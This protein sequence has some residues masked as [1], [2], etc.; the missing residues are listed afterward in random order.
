MFTKS[1]FKNSLLDELKPTEI[2]SLHQTVPQLKQLC[3]LAH[4]KMW[5]LSGHDQKHS[6]FNCRC[7][8]PNSIR[9]TSYS[10]NY[11]RMKSCNVIHKCAVNI[12]LHIPPEKDIQGRVIREVCEPREIIHQGLST[13]QHISSRSICFITLENDKCLQFFQLCE[14]KQLEHVN[15]DIPCDKDEKGYPCSGGLQNA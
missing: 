15:V 13:C 6:Q 9:H 1:C 4:L 8:G 3:A 10:F 7:S 11:P 5:P 2:R 14:H 12:T